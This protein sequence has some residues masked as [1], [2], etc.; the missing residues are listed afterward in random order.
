M[1]ELV[2]V[3]HGENCRG[4]QTTRRLGLQLGLREQGLLMLE[5]E[6]M[7]LVL[8]VL[9]FRE[10]RLC[11]EAW[12]VGLLN[13]VCAVSKRRYWIFSGV[14][15]VA[16]LRIVNNSFFKLLSIGWRWN[17]TLLILPEL[18]QVFWLA[19]GAAWLP[20]TFFPILIIIFF[21][22]NTIWI[23]IL[24]ICLEKRAWQRRLTRSSGPRLAYRA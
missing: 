3:L 8:V 2:G 20:R 7:A 17:Q 11:R 19:I 24:I 22:E 6:D 16:S 13:E 4:G 21:P 1:V 5:A 15:W 9:Q 10:A 12:G 14:L 18:L 23:N